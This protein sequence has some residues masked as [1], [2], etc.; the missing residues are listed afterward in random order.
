[1]Q[2]C[3]AMKVNVCGY[4]MN[5]QGIQRPCRSSFRGRTRSPDISKVP[6]DATD[7]VE[8]REWVANSKS[9]GFALLSS[10]WSIFVLRWW[11]W[12]PQF[13]PQISKILV[14]KPFWSK[15]S[16]LISTNE[17]SWCCILSSK[18]SGRLMVLE[19]ASETPLRYLTEE[20]FFRVLRFW[21]G[22]PYCAV[23]D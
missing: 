13:L 6:L 7:G 17:G 16:I 4:E 9:N 5:N 22:I 19:R 10:V 21:G 2:R 23:N 20:G 3:I 15:R 18:N 8:F 1:M 14:L 11:I 12:T